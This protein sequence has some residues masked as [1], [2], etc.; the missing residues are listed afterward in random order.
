MSCQI[1]RVISS[2]SISTTGFF[3]LIFA[4]LRGHLLSAGRQQSSE[5]AADDCDFGIGTLEQIPIR[6]NQATPLFH[7]S[8]RAGRGRIR[9]EA[10]KP[11][12]G[13]SPSDPPDVGLRLADGPPHPTSSRCSDVDL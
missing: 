10:T 5:V 1:M 2:P 8:P 12:G 3:T 6:L 4:I 7:L 9:R 13:D 11:G